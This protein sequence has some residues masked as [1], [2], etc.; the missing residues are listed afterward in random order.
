M[1]LKKKIKHD[2]NGL[3][4][5]IEVIPNVELEKLLLSF[6]ENLTINK[7]IA[8]KENIIKRLKAAIK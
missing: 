5:T 6:G 7:P 8:F 3:L 4:I 2:D 1:A